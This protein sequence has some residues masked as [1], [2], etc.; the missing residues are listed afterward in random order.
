MKEVIV[1]ALL[2]IGTLGSLA[3]ASDGSIQT[4]NFDARIQTASEDLRSWDHRPPSRR[5]G[6]P[7][8]SYGGE[9]LTCDGNTQAC[10]CDGP[11]PVTRSCSCPRG[12][13]GES[14]LYQRHPVK[15]N[16]YHVTCVP[17]RPQYGQE[18]AYLTCD[19]N[20]HACPCDGPNP[21]TR[22]CSCPYGTYPTQPVWYQSHPVKG[23]MYR[24]DCY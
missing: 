2:L 4:P 24:V 14:R 20:T 3:E 1:L 17:D 10:P 21:Y 18:N 16:M 12:Y 19:G 15:G 23:N 11:N 8:H 22:T 5:P 6:R 7:G 9:Y 13:V